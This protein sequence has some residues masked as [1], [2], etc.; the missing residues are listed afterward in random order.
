MT[1]IDDE[2]TSN[3]IIKTSNLIFD[4]EV[5]WGLKKTHLSKKMC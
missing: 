4:V 5:V 3:L 2:P 1:R